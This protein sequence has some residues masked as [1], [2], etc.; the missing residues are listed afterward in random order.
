[1]NAGRAIVCGALCALLGSCSLFSRAMAKPAP[2]KPVDNSETYLSIGDGPQSDVDLG[3][4]QKTLMEE[5][6]AVQT[7][8]LALEQRVKELEATNETLRVK[9]A[10]TEEERDKE[11]TLGSGTQAELERLR[12]T[13]AMRE[14]KILDLTLEKAR[15]EQE[16]LKLRI[17]SLQGQLEQM[18]VPASEPAAPGA[19]K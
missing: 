3:P 8:K 18:G 13:L 1:M 11:R 12:E 2:E 9:L 15:I 5:F 7:A 16:M 4:G 17:A 19:R 6:V 14:S 10:H